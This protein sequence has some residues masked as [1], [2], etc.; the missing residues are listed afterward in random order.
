MHLLLYC[1]QHPVKSL[2]LRLHDNNSRVYMLFAIRIFVL[3]LDI[4][5]Q[6]HTLPD[7]Q[8]HC[9]KSAAQIK[10]AM[11]SSSHFLAKVCCSYDAGIM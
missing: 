11:Q 3:T 1:N 5:M 10:I 6:M 8:E 9:Y 2:T 4:S 7:V